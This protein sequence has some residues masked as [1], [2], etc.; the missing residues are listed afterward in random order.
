[1]CWVYDMNQSKYA[2]TAGIMILVASVLYG[3]IAWSSENSIT[4]GAFAICIYSYMI[5]W[6]GVGG[7]RGACVVLPIL[8]FSALAYVALVGSYSLLAGEFDVVLVVLGGTIR[9]GTLVWREAV[10][11]SVVST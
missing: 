10:R 1:M 11:R 3:A 7:W 9:A 6:P 5:F 4:F 2:D 8:A